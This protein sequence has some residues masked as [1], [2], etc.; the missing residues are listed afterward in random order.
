MSDLDSKACRNAVLW[1]ATAVAALLLMTAAAEAAPRLPTVFEPNRGQADPGARFVARTAGYTLLLTPEGAVVADR[2]TGDRVR[3]RLTGARPDVAIVGGERLPGRTHYL[4]GRDPSGWRTDVPH[5]ARVVYHD[6]YPGIDAIYRTETG[7]I[8]QDFVVRPGADPARIRL[9]FDGARHVEVTAEGDLLLATAGAP[10]RLSRPVAYQDGPK[11]RRR[12]P[13]A[14][15]V[16]EAS[17]GFEVG[18]WDRSRALVIDPVIVWA[19]RLGGGGD[20]AVFGVA[21]NAVGQVHV[22][23]ETD[24]VDFPTTGGVPLAGGS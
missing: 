19:T 8:A 3:I 13:A 23:G 17:A 20:D 2:K 14:W 24:S 11:G 16:D 9:R 22:A 21:V 4:R 12:V 6:A 10:L 15:T 18:P 7:G 5:Y 1:L